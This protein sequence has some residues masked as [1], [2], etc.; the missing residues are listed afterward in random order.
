MSFNPMR[1][2]IPVLKR[3]VPS[4]KKRMAKLTSADG[5]FLS[6]RRNLTFLLNYKNFVD[7]QIAFYDDFESRQLACFTSAMKQHGCDL[8]LDIG[9]NIGYYSLIIAKEGLAKRIIAFEPDERN[10]LQLGTNILLNH[11]TDKIE[12][13][14]KAVTAATGT[15]KFLPF[16]ETSTGQSHIGEGQN[17]IVVDGVCLDDLIRDKDLKIFIKMDIEGHELEAIRG[18]SKLAANN[19]LFLQVESFPENLDAVKVALSVMRLRYS[20]SIDHDHYFENF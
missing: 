15:V 5:Y 6:K 1:Y 7:R 11:L 14:A 16:S 10:R 13:M 3:L 9:A 2:N 20:S 8:F 4:L 17:S 12:I 18:M 19:K